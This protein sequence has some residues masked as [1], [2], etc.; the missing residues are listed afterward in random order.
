MS[1]A[2]ARPAWLATCA[3][4]LSLAA[5]LSLVACASAAEEKPIP[6]PPKVPLDIQY[7]DD[8]STEGPT[9]SPITPRTEPVPPDAVKGFL[10]LS[11]GDRVEGAIHLTRD[12]VLKFYH[13]EKKTLLSLRLSE[14]THIEQE[15]TVERM[16]K[17]WR[18]LENANDQKVYTGK[19]YPVRELETVLHTKDGRTL[20][21]ELTALLFVVN[22][23]GQ[24]R[25]VL[26]RRQK[27]DPGQKLSDLLYVK[28]VDFRQVAKKT[29]NKEEPPKTQ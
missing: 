19:E 8:D 11:S 23:N 16:E 4:A 17:E 1:K 22:D 3:A 2:N 18:W 28:L 24:Q 14:L 9:Q 10:V 5:V 12:A 20:R 29:D 27:G 25:F 6:E 15:P 21:G 26:H 13:A 7:A